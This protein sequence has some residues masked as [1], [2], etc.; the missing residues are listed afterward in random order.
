MR[1]RVS[2]PSLLPPATYPPHSQWQA[3][4]F[5]VQPSTLVFLLVFSTARFPPSTQVSHSPL[6]QDGALTISC[7]HTHWVASL[8][9]PHEAISQSCSVSAVMLAVSCHFATAGMCRVKLSANLCEVHHGLTPKK[10]D[11]HEDKKKFSRM[12]CWLKLQHKVKQ[13]ARQCLM[14]YLFSKCG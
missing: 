1:Q 11:G 4:F 14:V 12:F 2:Q 3:V 7:A 8:C 6:R 5:R 10:D 9:C 13:S